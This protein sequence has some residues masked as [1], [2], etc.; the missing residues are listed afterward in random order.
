MKITQKSKNIKNKEHQNLKNILFS[1]SK[2]IFGSSIKIGVKDDDDISGWNDDLEFKYHD[3]GQQP[4]SLAWTSS[5][6][7]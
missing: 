2:P 3:L 7:M 4:V 6:L 1:G 5:I